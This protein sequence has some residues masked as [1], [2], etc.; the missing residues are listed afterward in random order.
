MVRVP[1][2]A[3]MKHIAAIRRNAF[4]SVLVISVSGDWQ[5]AAIYFLAAL[6]LP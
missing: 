6:S 1:D 5:L 2:L 4:G 3:A